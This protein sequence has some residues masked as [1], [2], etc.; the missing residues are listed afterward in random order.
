MTKVALPT[1]PHQCPTWPHLC[2]IIPMTITL[3]IVYFCTSLEVSKCDSIAIV[4]VHVYAPMWRVY[5]CLYVPMCTLYVFVCICTYF[6]MCMYLPSIYCR[7]M[8][9]CSGW[10]VV[11]WEYSLLLRSNGWSTVSI[12]SKHMPSSDSILHIPLFT[13]L[14]LPCV[15]KPCLPHHAFPPTFLGHT[16]TFSFQPIGCHSD[17]WNHIYLLTAYHWPSTNHFWGSL[18]VLTYVA[19]TFSFPLYYSSLALVKVPLRMCWVCV[20]VGCK[21]L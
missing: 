2:A 3:Q 14:I 8:S 1:W 12:L 11:G 4:C 13:P 18:R 6:Y 10:C 7:H 20:S 5:V 19:F 16:S 15:G 9:V 21:Y 17:H